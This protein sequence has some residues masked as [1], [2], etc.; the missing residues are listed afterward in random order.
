MNRLLA[1]KDPTWNAFGVWLSKYGI[2]LGIGFAVLLAT[3]AVIFFILRERAKKEYKEEETKPVSKPSFARVDIYSML[4]GRANV[5]KHD[6]VNS[7]IIL[8][9]KDDSL[10]DD[11]L[12]KGIGVDSIMKMSGKTILVVKE[13]AESFYSLFN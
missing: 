2:W 9:L 13:G 3:V 6:R 11:D 4:G 5:I 8:E 1:A 7:R 12:L 10:I